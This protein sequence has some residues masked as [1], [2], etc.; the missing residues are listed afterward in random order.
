[1]SDES[2]RGTSRPGG[3]L[4]RIALIVFVVIVVANACA[5]AL[6]PALLKHAPGVL[7]M[8]DDQLPALILVRQR[9]SWHGFLIAIAIASIANFLAY[10]VGRHY[11]HAATTRLQRVLPVSGRVV[12]LLESLFSSTSGAPL[13]LIDN[14]V[15]CMLAGASGISL[16]AFTT[17]YVLAVALRL[18][19]IGL[20]YRYVGSG[21]VDADRLIEKFTI[22]LTAVAVLAVAIDGLV[23]RHSRSGK[24]RN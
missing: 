8:L 17:F 15:S 22:P 24:A 16:P 3:A 9:L 18:A 5:Q 7:A 6:A 19:L 21:L 20:L 4:G 11:G 10:Y 14:Y 13:L 23:A 2:A 12:K 1:M